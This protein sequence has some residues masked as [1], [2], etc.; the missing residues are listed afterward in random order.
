VSS[1]YPFHFNC[2]RCGNCCR[3]GHGHVWVKAEDVQVMADTKQMTSAAFVE[4]FLYSKDS[5]L[6]VREEANGACSLLDSTNCCSVYDCRPE[7]CSSFPYWPQLSTQGPALDM[8]SA[9]CPGIQKFPSVEL[10]LEVL[11]QVHTLLQSYAV[12]CDNRET[13]GERWGTSLEVDLKLSCGF[14]L[15]NVAWPHSQ[16]LRSEL[17]E[18]AAN[19]GYPYSVSPW[20]RL[21]FDRGEGWHNLGGIPVIKHEC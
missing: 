17:E 1:D 13:E 16:Q 2:H 15:L 5:K 7:Q 12:H 8:A 9:Y 19:N 10:A 20:Q 11:P 18:M 6:S 21:L 4:R 14:E 3:I